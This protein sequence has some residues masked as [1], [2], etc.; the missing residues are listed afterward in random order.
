MSSGWIFK[1]QRHCIHDGPGIRTTVFF[2]GCPLSCLW[3]FNPESQNPRPEVVHS[4]DKCIVCGLCLKECPVPGA[5]QPDVHEPEGPIG[6]SKIT[7]NKQL[8]TDCGSCLEVC[9]TGALSLIGYQISSEEVV[10]TV[11]RDRVFYEKSGGGVTL[12]GGEVALQPDFAREILKG[13]RDK[14]IHTAIETCGHA[15]WREMEKVLE[16]TDTVLYDLK[17][18]NSKK[19]LEFTG[20]SSELIFANMR[21]ISDAGKELVLR[22]PLIPGLNDGE[23]DLSAAAELILSLPACAGVHLLPYELLGVDKYKKL[24]R[25][26]ELDKIRPPGEDFLEKVQSFFAARGIDVQIGG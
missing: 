17:I 8:C 11:L 16:Y 4:P 25:G 19:H 22:L 15:P 13:C 23:D 2:K 14:G 12:S 20:V 1:I 18:V 3:C 21:K 10:E 24:G 7:H 26:Y 6:K 9:P 5:L